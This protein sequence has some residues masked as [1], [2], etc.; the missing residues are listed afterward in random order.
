M[1]DRLEPCPFCGTDE[2]LSIK[3]YETQVFHDQLFY[4]YCNKCEVN[5]VPDTTV[6]GAIEEWNYAISERYLGGEAY[7]NEWKT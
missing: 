5:S 2:E 6:K 3:R 7:K 1:T 4:V